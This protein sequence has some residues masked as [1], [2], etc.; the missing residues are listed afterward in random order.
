MSSCSLHICS[1]SSLITFRTDC[2]K[3]ER[4]EKALRVSHL[5][6]TGPGK[7]GPGGGQHAD[8]EQQVA[9]GVTA[10]FPHRNGKTFFLRPA[11]W[12]GLRCTLNEPPAAPQCHTGG[13]SLHIGN[14]AQGLVRADRHTYGCN[15]SHTRDRC[16]PPPPQPQ[17]TAHLRTL[18]RPTELSLTPRSRPH[19]LPPT[20]NHTSP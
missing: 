17:H 3:E 16:Q 11:P 2:R 19:S 9:P 1:C 7:S 12:M 14:D 6:D 10:H 18:T 5:S 4:G 8:G 13:P 20:P 15:P